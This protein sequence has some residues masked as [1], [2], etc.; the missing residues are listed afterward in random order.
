MDLDKFRHE[1]E[2]QERARIVAYLRHRADR[3]GE[4]G[5]SEQRDEDAVRAFARASSLRSAAFRIENRT[6]YVEE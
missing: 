2:A 6:M 3:Y 4:Q 1:V 5:R